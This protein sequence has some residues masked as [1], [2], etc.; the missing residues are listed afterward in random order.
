MALASP[1]QRFV[2]SGGK[3]VVWSAM[4][5][6]SALWWLCC[7]PVHFPV[8]WVFQNVTRTALD[9]LGTV[10]RAKMVTLSNKTRKATR[11]ALKWLWWL[12]GLYQIANGSFRPTIPA[13]FKRWCSL[14]CS[15][16]GIA[17]R[18]HAWFSWMLAMWWMSKLSK[19]KS[20]QSFCQRK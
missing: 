5:L 18:F 15:T 17:D 6:K 11:A 1:V 3:F 9:G 16:F 12:C 19:G 4:G 8:G 10:F 7:C 20:G 14:M 13:L 2:F